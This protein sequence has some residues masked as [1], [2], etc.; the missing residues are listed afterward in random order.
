MGTQNN[1]HLSILCLRSTYADWLYYTCCLLSYGRPYISRKERHFYGRYY[2]LLLAVIFQRVVYSSY[3]TRYIEIRD[4]YRVGYNDR[5]LWLFIDPHTRSLSLYICRSLYFAPKY[6]SKQWF[7]PVLLSSRK[8]LVLED[9]RGPICKSLSLNHKDLENFRGLRILQTVCYRYVWSSEVH[10]NSVTATVHEVTVKKNGLGL[11]TDIRYY[12]YRYDTDV[13]SVSKPLFTVT[14]CCVLEV[15]PCPGGSSRTIYKS[16]SLSSSLNPLTSTLVLITRFCSC[17]S[18]P[19]WTIT[20]NIN[21]SSYI[22]LCDLNI[23]ITHA[24]DS[25]G[26]KTFIRVCL[27]VRVCVCVCVSVCLYVCLSV[28]TITQNRINL[29]CSNLV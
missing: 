2:L 28:C 26:S 7:L 8:V 20:W 1:E 23:L 15:R 13:M 14:Q 3:L 24:D 11:L 22:G 16:L 18:L 17:C 5:R 9:P 27:C 12:L 25:C 6:Y 10:I 29:K 4:W 19:V 21:Y